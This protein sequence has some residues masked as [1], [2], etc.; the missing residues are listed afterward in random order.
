MGSTPALCRQVNERLK[1]KSSKHEISKTTGNQQP[2]T[3]VMPASTLLVC[4]LDQSEKVKDK[5][6]QCASDLSTVNVVLRQEIA[7]APELDEIERAVRLSEKVEV[8]VQQVAEQLATVND[9]LTEEIDERKNLDQALLISNAA[10]L[11]SREQEE[12][13][14]HLALHDAVTGLPNLMLFND[15]LSQ[16]LAHAR[17]EG[18]RLAVMFL[19]LDNFKAINDAHGHD[20]GDSVL[21]M[22]A[23]RLQAIVRAGD[24][25][26]RRSGD[27]FLFLMLDVGDEKSATKLAAK[28]IDHVGRAGEVGG[29]EFTVRAS[30]GIALHPEHG[31]SSQELLKN[32][33]VAMYAAKQHVEGFSIF[34]PG[35]QE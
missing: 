6:E 10:L 34:T 12:K 30:I 19:D 9:A 18:R 35:A 33:D 17:R 11:E 24:T 21:Q 4:A 25:V 28:I 22:V 23:Q 16:A 7:D 15:R 1:L 29:V 26:G 14:M 2:G 27:E 3:T 20:F 31:G 13:A 5:V 32:A 8:K